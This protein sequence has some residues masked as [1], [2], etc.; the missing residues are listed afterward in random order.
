MT[1]KKKVC[2]NKRVIV[3]SF[4][5]KCLTQDRFCYPPPPNR[6]FKNK[7][8]WIVVGLGCCFF[9]FLSIIFSFELQACRC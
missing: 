1:F 7:P 5:F 9:F 3:K 2:I 4:I 6:Y 8:K